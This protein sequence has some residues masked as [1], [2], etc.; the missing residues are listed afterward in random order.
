MTMANRNKKLLFIKK[1]QDLLERLKDRGIN[2][3]T[4]DCSRNKKRLSAR[5]VGW[6]NE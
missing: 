4:I 1:R 6:D 5:F 2:K 3:I